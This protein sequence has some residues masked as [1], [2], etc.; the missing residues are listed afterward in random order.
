VETQAEC[1]ETGHALERHA[2]EVGS[3]FIAVEWRRDHAML[4]GVGQ[5]DEHDAVG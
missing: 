3:V 2:S 5:V 1:G 4:D